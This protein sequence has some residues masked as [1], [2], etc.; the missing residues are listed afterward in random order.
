MKG[1][2]MSETR[3]R[4]LVLVGLC[5]AVALMATPAAAQKKPNILIVWGDDIGQFNI[6]AYNMKFL[7]KYPQAAYPYADLVATNKRRSRNDF[8]YELLDTGVFG[9]DRYFDVFVEYAKAS[10]EDILIQITACNRGAAEA[11]LHVLPTL[12][13]RN[14]WATWISRPAEKPM[15][16][17]IDGPA[18]TSTIAAAHD[19]GRCSGRHTPPAPTDAPSPSTIAIRS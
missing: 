19:L 15:L 6:S 8:E 18:G 14:N 5:A 2:G 3:R 12:W 10:P 4:L 11:E 7:Y 16:R 1:N 9:Q 13:F 17:Q